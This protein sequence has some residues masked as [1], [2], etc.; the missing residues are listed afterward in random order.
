MPGTS[1]S[2]S[3][4]VTSG[5]RSV[6]V[7][8]V[9]PVVSTARAPPST[10]SR[11]RLADRLAVGHHHRPVDLE[12]RFLRAPPR[13]AARWC[14]RRPRR[15]PGWRPRPRVALII[16]V[17]ADQSPLLPP[18]LAS[19]RTSLMTAALSTALTMSTTVS[20]GDGH[21]GQ[22]LHLHPG[23]VRG[24]HGRG[25]LDGVVGDRRGRR[26]PRTDR[27]R[28]AQRHQVRRPLRRHDPGHPG[29]AERVALGHALAAQQRRPPRRRRAPARW[30]RAC[31]R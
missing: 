20:A 28:V 9:P 16:A 18:V 12:P 22:R 7:R 25:D 31:R 17:S 5:V 1:R 29:H 30:P 19:T 3:G 24:A 21:R 11:M 14:P 27:Q 26:S 10:A 8:P 4:R 15:P 2:S 6:G 23:P 13:S